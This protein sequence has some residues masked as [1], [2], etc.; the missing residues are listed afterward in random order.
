MGKTVLAKSLARAP[1]A[2]SSRACSAPPT[3]SRPTSPASRSGTRTR[4]RFVFR[5]GPVFAN[6]VLVDEINRAS[7]KTQS[8]LL[9]CMEEGQVTVDGETRLLPRPFMVIATQNPV[10]YEGTFPLPEAQLDRFAV[11]VVDRLPAARR[12]GGDAARPGRATIPSSGVVPVTDRGRHRSP[13]G[14][15][16][17]RVHA[18]PALAQYVVALTAVT[19]RD[20]RVQLGA[21]PRAGLALLRAAKARALLERPRLRAARGRARAGD[22]RRCRTG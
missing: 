7:P 15:P 14:P 1:R 4:R 22:L 13:R 9:E 3:C 18:D 2:A 10:E 20:P 11:R 17:P 16:S 12:R 5:P 21:S 19:R 8:A 6:L